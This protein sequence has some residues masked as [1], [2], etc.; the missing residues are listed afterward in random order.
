MNYVNEDSI[1][2]LWIWLNSNAFRA[3]CESNAVVLGGGALKL[4]AI[5]LIQIGVPKSFLQLDANVIDKLSNLLFSKIRSDVEL[6][7]IGHI[8]DIHFFNERIAKE[9]L[10]L[11]KSKLRQRTKKVF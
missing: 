6:L 7:N 10:E 8:I 3:I 2:R 4:E 11:V 9:N 1:I 5:F